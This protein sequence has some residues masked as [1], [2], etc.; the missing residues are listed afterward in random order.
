LGSYLKRQQSPRIAVLYWASFEEY[1]IANIAIKSNQKA[2]EQGTFW[3]LFHL[4]GVGIEWQAEG[5]PIPTYLEHTN[6]GYLMG[7]EIDGY[8]GTRK[9][10]EFLNDVIARFLIT[11]ADLR[12]QRLPYKP[13]IKADIAHYYPKIYKLKELQALKS[14]SKKVKAPQRADSFDDYMFWAIKLFCEDLIRSQGMAVYHQLEDFAYMNFETKERSTLRA[15]CRSIYNWY[16]DRD[17]DIPRAKTSKT[18]KEIQMTRQERARKNA[19]AKALKAK[20]AVINAVTG[21]YA[22]E[23]KKKSGA[24]HIGKIA[25]A[26]GLHREVVSKYLK[27]WEANKDG[28]FEV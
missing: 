26:T 25:E 5:L 7:Y 19:E 16:A 17:W 13:H 6:R 2:P 14:L 15:K 3:L 22:D 4:Y 12:P 27:Q 20:K 8:F 10:S 18:E 24:W 21:L 23:Y 9:G 11:F 28:L 1:I